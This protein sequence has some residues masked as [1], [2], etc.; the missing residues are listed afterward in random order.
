MKLK[1][2]TIIIDDPKKWDKSTSPFDDFPIEWVVRDRTGNIKTC[3]DSASIFSSKESMLVACKLFI[4]QNQHSFIYAVGP[5][6]G[7][8]RPHDMK[9]RKFPALTKFV[10]EW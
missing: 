3:T 4:Q 6:G 2:V 9:V 10:R 8:Y 5:K 1:L 7:I